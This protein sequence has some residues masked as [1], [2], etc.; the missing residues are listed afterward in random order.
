ME[1]SPT[2]PS[3]SSSLQKKL[4]G[5][6]DELCMTRSFR[7]SDLAGIGP[8]TMCSE[9]MDTIEERGFS[10]GVGL[11]WSQALVTELRAASAASAARGFFGC[12]PSPWSSMVWVTPLLTLRGRSREYCLSSIGSNCTC[13]GHIPLGGTSPTGL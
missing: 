7:T 3:A 6:R 8:S 1:N 9:L 11:K 10:E 13:R 2:S 4:S 5:I 12:T